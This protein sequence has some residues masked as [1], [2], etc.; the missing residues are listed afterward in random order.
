MPQT[1][2]KLPLLQGHKNSNF[3]SGEES[4][5]RSTFT[6]AGSIS[7]FE[8]GDRAILKGNSPTSPKE[9]GLKVSAD[10]K[11]RKSLE[12]PV[13]SASL[14]V[15]GSSSSLTV[16]TL[17]NSTKEEKPNHFKGLWSDRIKEKSDHY[18]GL[19]SDR[20]KE[21][22]EFFL[23]E[24]NQLNTS[25]TNIDSS[26]NPNVK[27]SKF[28]K[29]LAIAPKKASLF[30]RVKTPKKGITKSDCSISKDAFTYSSSAPNKSDTKSV[31]EKKENL[32][33][34]IADSN[35]PNT[36]KPECFV[37]F[38]TGKPTMTYTDKDYL[39]AKRLSQNISNKRLTI[40]V[41]SVL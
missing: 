25:S 2:K 41:K 17:V 18:K 21:K 24:N 39:Q 22:S 10:L 8:K 12:A 23:Q 35:T 32:F 34:T 15:S 3:K 16:T 33:S 26:R 9:K 29:S 13:N 4:S 6:S 1:Q 20:I 7:F 5:S 38:N 27:E 30:E 40:I 19:W 14:G 36:H 37:T 31:I 28:K 11:L